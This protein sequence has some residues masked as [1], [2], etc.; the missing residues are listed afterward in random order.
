M[1]ALGMIKQSRALDDLVRC[2]DPLKGRTFLAATIVLGSTLCGA[3]NY[4]AL[5][6][7]HTPM[8][9]LGVATVLG[10]VLSVTFTSL[11]VTKE[12]VSRQKKMAKVVYW[13][14][15]ICSGALV[16]VGVFSAIYFGWRNPY[17]PLVAPFFIVAFWLTAIVCWIVGRVSFYFLAP[18]SN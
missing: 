15:R 12:T 13:S 1:A 14:G 7:Q 10:W 3:V 11:I 9:W 18:N 5:T 4:T 8:V 16:I 17:W 2:G 6:W